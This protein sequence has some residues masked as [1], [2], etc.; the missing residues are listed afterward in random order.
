LLIAAVIAI[1]L[2]LLFD[3]Q[4]AISAM[5]GGMVSIVSSAAFAVIVS[6]HRGY[7]AGGTLRT[8]LRAEA[9]KI[10]LIVIMLWSVLK[11]Y[12][13]VNAFAFIGTFTLTVIVYSLALF[14]SDNTKTT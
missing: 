7:T 1:A 2:G 3:L 10:I 11:L 5:L 13:D 12:A 4:S 14:I 8:A 9:V 6:R